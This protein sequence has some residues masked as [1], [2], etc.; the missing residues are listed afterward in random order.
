MG[1]R[2]PGCVRKG[3]IRG[4]RHPGTQAKVPPGVLRPAEFWA[5]SRWGHWAG[6]VG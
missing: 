6:S 4:K 2:A 1:N 3:G 5:W